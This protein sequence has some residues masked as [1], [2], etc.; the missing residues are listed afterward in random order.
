VV[1]IAAL[2]SPYQDSRDFVRS[3][4]GNFI[5]VHVSTPLEVCEARDVKGLYKKARRGE[6]SHFTGIDDPYEPPVEPELVLDT[7]C[8]SVEEATRWVLAAL[9]GGGP[10]PVESLVRVGATSIPS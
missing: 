3:L 10:L 9:T 8:L 6:I 7:S 4:C 5:E 2:V 1:V